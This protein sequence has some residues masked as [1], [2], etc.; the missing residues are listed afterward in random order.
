MDRGIT[1]PTLEDV[2]LWDLSDRTQ[3]RRDELARDLV[4]QAA[5][6][7]ERRAREGSD[8]TKNHA[9]RD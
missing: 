1:L 4:R 6:E 2:A 7:R 3:K 8:G 9:A 5:R